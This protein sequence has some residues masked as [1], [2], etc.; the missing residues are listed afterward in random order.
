MT[1]NRMKGVA[2]SV[3]AALSTATSGCSWM[4][5][6]RAPQPVLAPN[7][8]VECSS[9][10]AA[11][12]LDSICAG[13]FVANTI[14]LASVDDDCDP[15]SF[16]C[17]DFRSAKTSAMLVGAGVAGLCALSAASGFKNANR[18]GSVKQLNAACIT[19][20]EQACFALSPRWTPRVRGAPAWG[21]PPSGAVPSP[22]AAPGSAPAPAPSSWDEPAR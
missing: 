13:Y 22:A 17:D 3:I 14:A 19:G 16:G 15:S 8:P 9:S 11:P 12:V 7:Y 20:N 21:E 18:C 5:M 10:R 2:L 6:Q 1:G 4:F